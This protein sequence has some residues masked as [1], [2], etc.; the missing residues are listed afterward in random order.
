MLFIPCLKSHLFRHLEF[1][2]IYQSFDTFGPVLIVILKL[3]SVTEYS[4]LFQTSDYDG[5]VRP[6]TNLVAVYHPVRMGLKSSFL[7]WCGF[8]IIFYQTEWILKCANNDAFR[9]F[10][11]ESLLLD[12]Q[13]IILSITFR[14]NGCKIVV[15]LGSCNTRSSGIDFHDDGC[16]NYP[17]ELVL[18]YWRWEILKSHLC[19]LH[20]PLSLVHQLLF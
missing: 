9:H 16:L 15:V 2:S 13:W 3:F 18:L 5:T 17:L 12:S 20:S 10:D 7:P 19:S 4:H 8:M 6:T 14:S 11:C 1:L